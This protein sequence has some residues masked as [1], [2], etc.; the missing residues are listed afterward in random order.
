MKN[1]LLGHV[2]YAFESISLFQTGFLYKDIVKNF[3]CISQFA[4]QYC[5]T[6]INMINVFWLYGLLAICPSV[7]NHSFI[8][9]WIDNMDKIMIEGHENIFRNQTIDGSDRSRRTKVLKVLGW[10]ISIYPT[11]IVFRKEKWEIYQIIIC[12]SP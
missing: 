10:F 3:F 9:S 6:Y 8:K 4:L 11:L 12:P 7:L 5:K 2:G 1:C